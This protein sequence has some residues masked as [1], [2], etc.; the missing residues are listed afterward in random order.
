MIRKIKPPAYIDEFFPF[1]QI[2]SKTII[3]WI[4]SGKIKGEQTPA[5][6]WLVVINE[7]ETSKVNTM[8]QML[9]ASGG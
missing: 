6:R 1:S 3:N 5:G 2:T 4:K 8:L 9:E 7:E